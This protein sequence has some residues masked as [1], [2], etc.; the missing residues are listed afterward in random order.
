MKTSI[1]IL[2]LLSVS[3]HA[4]LIDENFDY[5][6]GTLTVA[7][8]NWTEFPVGSTDIQITPGSLSYSNYPSSG[9]G[10]KIVLDGGATGRSGILRAFTSQT[11]N[12]IV[13][14]AS[15][16]L[17]VTST[18]DMD[19]SGSNGDYFANLKVSGSNSY[20]C[21]IFVKQG[22]LSSK[23]R[24]GLGKLNTSTPSWHSSELDVNTTY[25]LVISYTFQSGADAARLWINPSLSGAEPAADLEQTTGTDAANIGEIQF[26]Q[27]SKS[28]DM[29][30][31][32]VRVATSWSLAPL[33]VEL[34]AF[35]A[36]IEGKSVNLFWETATE[37]DNYGFEI[38]RSTG[39]GE[40][41]WQ[42]IGFVKG[43][44]NSNSVKY[45]SFTDMPLNGRKFNYRLKQIDSG[46]SYEYSSIISVELTE[47][48]SVSLEQNFPNPFNPVTTIN[49]SVPNRT[50]IRIR[51]YNLLSQCV[52]DLVNEIKNE[53]NYQIR[54]DAS[55]LPSGIYFCELR[56]ENQSLVK[57]LLLIK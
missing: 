14:Y 19:T 54:F 28:G 39:S 33:P 30:I 42:K 32:G 35:T 48:F 24:L 3:L 12:G 22:S 27:Q 53:G 40:S 20:R 57:K 50:K 52:A 25:L 26:R 4:Q 41:E 9:I 16:L 11:G 34:V 45:Y 2:F 15:F 21:A 6:T 38:E 49:Y 7:T 1:L 17:N 37:I 18:A 31:D 13:V 46:G 5:T 43:N 36:S 56:T 44:G 51:I 29:Q 23:F 10:N 55:D 8:A 47:I